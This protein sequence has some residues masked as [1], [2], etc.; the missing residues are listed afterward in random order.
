MLDFTEHYGTLAWRI[1]ESIAT[2]NV[3][4]GICRLLNNATKQSS[5]PKAQQIVVMNKNAI[6]SWVWVNR[7][8]A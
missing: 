7:L 8:D 5:A 1:Q 4:S 6:K 2:I 3:S